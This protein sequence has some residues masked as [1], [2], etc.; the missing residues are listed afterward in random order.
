VAFFPAYLT[1]STPVTETMSSPPPAAFAFPWHIPHFFTF[2]LK[3]FSSRHLL[4]YLLGINYKK[5]DILQMQQ[6]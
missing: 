6:P 3:H 4:N 1:S 2:L 5:I